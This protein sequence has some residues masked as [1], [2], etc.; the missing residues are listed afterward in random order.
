[1]RLFCC[2]KLPFYNWSSL[3]TIEFWNVFAY[4][5]SFYLQLRHFCLQM[6]FFAC[7]GKVRLVNTPMDSKRRSS[8]ASKE[9]PTVSEKK[10]PPLK[11]IPSKWTRR[12]W[13]ANCCWTPLVTPA[14]PLKRRPWVLCLV[15][16]NA[17]PA[18]TFELFQSQ[19]CKGWLPGA[20]ER[21]FGALQQSVPQNG[22]V[23]LHITD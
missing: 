5:W 2:W 11:S 8:T 13:V 6:S 18:S 9:T 3:L 7:S 15:S 22:R 23:H 4:S 17:N 16:K 19:R 12:V 1:M 14:E 21:L 10:L 20:E